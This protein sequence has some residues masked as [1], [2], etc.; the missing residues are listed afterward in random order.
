DHTPTEESKCPVDHSASLSAF[1]P[2][3]PELDP[4]NNMPLTPEQRAHPTQQQLSTHRTVSSI[5][6][7]SRYQ[8]SECPTVDAQSD[9]WVYPSEQMFF[10]AMKRKQWAPREQDMKT[11]VPIHNIVNEMCWS[12]I[13]EWERMH[14]GCLQPKL[15]KFEGKAKQPSPKAR[16][17]AMIGYQ[18]PFD[19]HDWTVDR[20]GKQ[21]RY[22]IDFYQGKRDPANP[23]KPS[24]F[25]DVRPA[26]TVEG[27]WDRTRRFLGI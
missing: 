18:M 1:L 15:L 19:R 6:R 16:V 11:V 3:G 7:A 26:L 22:V 24:F 9:N 5:P 25:V 20:C 23:D 2:Q 12:Q 4:H 27:A 21:V 14:E 17:R 13:L 8:Q 10:N